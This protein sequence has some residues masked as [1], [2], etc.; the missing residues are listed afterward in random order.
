MDLATLDWFRRLVWLEGIPG[1][2]WSVFFLRN[3]GTQALFLCFTITQAVVKL[4]K[5]SHRGDARRVVPSNSVLTTARQAPTKVPQLKWPKLSTTDM[6]QLRWPKLSTTHVTVS[7]SVL[8]QG[9]RLVA[10][11]ASM[12]SAPTSHLSNSSNFSICLSAN[13]VSTVPVVIFAD[14]SLPSMQSRR[15]PELNRS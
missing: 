14:Y 11:S 2:I 9:W 13:F 3:L 8:V 1:C 4:V 10:K 12:P 7:Q 15:R 5:S 6:T